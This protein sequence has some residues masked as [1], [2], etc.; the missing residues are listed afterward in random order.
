MR[1]HAEDRTDRATPPHLVRALALAIVLNACG[2]DDG[3]AGG[4][5][6]APA[7]DESSGAEANPEGA[8]NRVLAL[9]MDN[10]FWMALEARDALI[11]GG[12]DHARNRMRRLS[13]REYRG[14]VPDP[15]LP[16]MEHMIDE[17]R[18]VAAAGDL[19]EASEAMARVAVAC[20][21]CHGKLHVGP[22]PGSAPV[23]DSAE[24]G[25]DL[26]ER[27]LRHQW[28]ADALW[29]GLTRPSD[30]DWRSGAEALVD[31]PPQPPASPDGGV[32]GPEQ[33]SAMER[34]RH[35]GQDALQSTVPEQRAKVYAELLQSC[36]GCHG[37]F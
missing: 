31:A 9:H 23:D 3:S 15:W 18:Q 6:A 1:A 21:A 13:E 25:E 30:A 37:K 12:L 4:G 34:V 36:S 26:T 22:L 32:V 29:S 35:I 24:D 33:Q 27:M 20:G 11:A 16:D 7:V 14:L 2:H 5:A 8:P 19:R 10:Y 28:A 17:A